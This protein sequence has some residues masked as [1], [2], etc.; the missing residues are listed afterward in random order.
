M[1]VEMAMPS[2]SLENKEN[3]VKSLLNAVNYLL[4]FCYNGQNFTFSYFN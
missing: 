3:K 1:L 4:R 2:N